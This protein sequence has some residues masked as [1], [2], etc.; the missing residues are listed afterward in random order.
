MNNLSNSVQ[1]RPVYPCEP[2]RGLSSLSKALGVQ[3]NLLIR[4]SERANHLYRV[5]KQDKKADGSIRQTFDAFP[6]LK[7][8]QTRIQFR[9]LKRIVYP[10]Y[11]QGSLRGCSP[12]TNA[13]I[14]VNAKIAFAEDIANFFPSAHYD[15][16][17]NIWAG[18]MGCSDDVAEILTM[19]T[20]KDNGLPQGAVTSS[21]LANLVFWNYEPH[22]VAKLHARGLKYSRY[23]DD[24]SVSCERRLQAGDQSRLVSEV[25]GMLLHH[26]FQPK[27][28]K[29]EVFTAGKSMRTTKLLSN[30][31]V[32]LPV[33][34]RQNIRAAVYALEKRVS[35]GERGI[36]VVKELARVASRVGRLGSFHVKE[37]VALKERLKVIRLVLVPFPS[38][39]APANSIKKLT[40]ISFTTD[41][42]LPWE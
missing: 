17:K 34:Q 12:R 7:S 16:I 14:H 25:Y 4:I 11:L 15:L 36:V 24:I 9:I 29:H 28:S 31:R 37:G 23:V 35:S 33:E 8:V 32:A 27:R 13:A 21:F 6:V 22:L 42:S 40:L 41:L 3:Q 1:F 30:K 39:Q 5:A 18:F 19:L 2:I 38:T 10:S 26:G 20:T